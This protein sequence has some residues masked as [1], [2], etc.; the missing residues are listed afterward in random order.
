MGKRF[1]T[2]VAAAF[3][4][5]SI[6]FLAPAVGAPAVGAAHTAAPPPAL[7]VAELNF[8]GMFEGKVQ[9]HRVSGEQQETRTYIM[10]MNPDMQNG[11][12][13]IY[14]QGKLLDV[15]LFAGALHGNTFTGKT[16]PVQQT[17]NYTPDNIRLDF[18]A[19]SK[20]VRWQH[21]DGTILGSGI[22]SRI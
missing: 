20:S 10:A 4:A 8:A 21:N 22:L 15:L 6:G 3:A 11:A 16:R 17:G 14:S 2:A 1:A 9:R 13:W 19:D 7:R 5:A 12:V 18:A